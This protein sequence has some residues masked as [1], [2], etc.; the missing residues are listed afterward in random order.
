MLYGSAV[1]STLDELKHGILTRDTVCIGDEVGHSQQE[2][3][4]NVQKLKKQRPVPCWSRGLGNMSGI[5]E[6]EVGFAGWSKL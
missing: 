2:W 3:P 4:T 5:A 6:R 1:L